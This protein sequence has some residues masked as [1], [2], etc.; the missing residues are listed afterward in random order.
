MSWKDL[1]VYLMELHK[2]AKLI[3]SKD[4]EYIIWCFSCKNYS[5]NMQ[6]KCLNVF[7][8]VFHKQRL[9]QY[10]SVI[11][12][13]CFLLL[14]AF[15]VAM[16]VPI[17]LLLISMFWFKVYYMVP[18]NISWNSKIVLITYFYYYFQ[19]IPFQHIWS[20]NQNNLHCS[21]SLE[22]IDRAVH[23]ISCKIQ[24]YQKAILSNRQV[25][26]IYNNFN[27]KSA[28]CQTP[29]STLKGRSSTVTTNSSSGF[30][31]MVTLDREPAVQGFR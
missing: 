4:M 25:L 6:Q 19:E 13:Y 28:S 20:G 30:S 29:S 9:S 26:H 16:Q 5:G 11:V 21:F 8:F 1:P 15:A 18:I 23:K 2:W 17:L 7:H 12:F 31:S 3:L 24:V 10:V 27:E 22:M 14:V